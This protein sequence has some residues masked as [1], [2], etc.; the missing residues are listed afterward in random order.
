[1]GGKPPNALPGVLTGRPGRR[2]T[3]L[4]DG[5]GATQPLWASVSPSVQW[6]GRTVT[7]SPDQHCS[8]ERS[9]VVSQ[10]YVRAVLFCGISYFI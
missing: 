9:G 8:V 6:R 2:L 1:M 5:E 3:E 7:E 10:S 4:W